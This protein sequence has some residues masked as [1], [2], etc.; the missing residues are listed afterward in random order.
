MVDV[1]LVHVYYF[2]KADLLTCLQSLFA[3]HQGAKATFSVTVVDNTNNRDDIATWLPASYPQVRLVDAG[4]NVGFGR[5]TNLG[6]QAERARYAMTMNADLRFDHTP[7]A[8]D[9]LVKYMDEHDQV[10]AA[11]PQL[12][13]VTGERQHSAYS[14]TLPA[15]LIKPLRVWP[16]VVDH[17]FIRPYLKLLQSEHLDLSRPRSVDWLLGAAIILRQEALDVVGAFDERYSLYF[18]DCDICHHLWERG[19][20]VHYLPQVTLTHVYQRA[21]HSNRSPLIHFFKSRPA[22]AHVKSWL[23]YMWKWWGRH[24]SYA[25]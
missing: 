5:G 20:E 9:E 13:Y 2:G 3:S 25:R 24:R 14:F 15:I 18:E 7:Q 11:G 4:G 19:W 1:H 8:L 17:P 23:Q 16:K 10:G 12:K 6:F 21:G 22:R